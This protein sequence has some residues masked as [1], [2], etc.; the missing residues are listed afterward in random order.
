RD[1]PTC[2]RTLDSSGPWPEVSRLAETLMLTTVFPA[3]LTAVEL[4]SFL[5]IP[6]VILRSREPLAAVAWI[7]GIILMPG[8]GGFL[9][10][11]IG[12]TRL[13]KTQRKQRTREVLGPQLPDLASHEITPCPDQGDRVAAELMALA[14]R[15]VDTRPTR[16]NQVDVITDTQAAYELQEQAIR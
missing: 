9:Y 13:A 16:G 5:L 14:C 15:I 3:I 12:T 11:A 1:H 10:L 8:L 2:D 6:V 4:L 7:L